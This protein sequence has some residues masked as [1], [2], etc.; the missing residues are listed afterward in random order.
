MLHVP[1][2]VLFVQEFSGVWESSLPSEHD[3]GSA[4]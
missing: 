1:Q 3:G 4:G 2:R